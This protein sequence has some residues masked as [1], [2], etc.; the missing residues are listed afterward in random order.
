M[1][2][3]EQDTDKEDMNRAIDVESPGMWGGVHV[4]RARSTT[5]W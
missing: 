1:V 4:E 5:S 3:L 2:K